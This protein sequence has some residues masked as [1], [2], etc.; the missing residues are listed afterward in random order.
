MVITWKLFSKIE[1]EQNYEIY[2]IKPKKLMNF[3]AWIDNWQQTQ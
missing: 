3:K 2:M 1:W